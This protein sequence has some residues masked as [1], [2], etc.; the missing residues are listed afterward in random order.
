MFESIT[1]YDVLILMSLMAVVTTPTT[2]ISCIVTN[3]KLKKEICKD[4][5]HYRAALAEQLN[6]IKVRVGVLEQR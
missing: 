6:Q 2:V 1:I 4:I 3:N 5:Q